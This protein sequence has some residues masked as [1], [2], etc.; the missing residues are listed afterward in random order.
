MGDNYGY[1]GY[2]NAN[3]G[4]QNANNNG[5]GFMSG[6]QQGS[7]D[8]PN[9]QK[10]YG[11]ESLRPVTI[12]QILDATQAHSDAEFKIDGS[13]VTQVSLVGQIST[14]SPRAT[15]IVYKIDD[16]TGTLEIQQWINSDMEEGATKPIALE[17]QYLH[18]WGRIK[19]LQNKR[20]VSSQMLRPVAD[21]NEVTYHLL[22]ATAIHLYFTRG[23]P[24][25]ATVKAEGGNG[26]FV[27]NNGGGN[28]GAAQGQA[29]GKK[30]PAKTSAIARKVY[31]LLQEAPQNNEGLHVQNIASQLGMQANDVFKAGDE[32]LGD[33]VIYTTVDD[34]TWAVLEY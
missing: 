13:E 1:Q 2:S 24:E 10:V 8:S 25:G 29:A 15:N 31:H 18:V 22:E 23:P 20:T 5:G 33:G 6:S 11:Q 14:I 32:L 7:Q 16:G 12:K 9:G 4:G 3:Y 17:G 30:L 21:F 26:M 27:D 28:V 19:G 34:E